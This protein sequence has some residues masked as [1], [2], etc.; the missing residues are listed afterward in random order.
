MQTFSAYVLK[1]SE[2]HKYSVATRMERLASTE[3]DVY[4]DARAFTSF[5]WHWVLILVTET[6]IDLLIVI[7][8]QSFPD[9]WE[10]L[11]CPAWGLVFVLV[12]DVEEA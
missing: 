2:G 7:V 1:E 12:I 8:L 6:S 11:D 9:H 10:R 4:S 5:L 3:I